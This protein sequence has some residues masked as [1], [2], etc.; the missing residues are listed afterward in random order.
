M[1]TEQSA[2]TPE[3]R[4]TTLRELLIHRPP[5]ARE[6]PAFEVAQAPADPAELFVDWLLAAMRGGVPDAQVLTLG[7][8]GL[9]GTPDARIVTLRDVDPA[10][11]EWWFWGELHS[12]KGRQLAADPRAALTWYWPALGRQVR[13]RGAVRAGSVAAAGETFRLLSPKSR[14]ASLVGRQ[15][16]PL[17][18]VAQFRAAWAAAERELAAD[19]GIVAAGYTQYAV[20]AEEVEFWQG[21]DDRRH[22]RLAYRRPAGTGEWT[23]GV[24]WP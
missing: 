10:N 5:M 12:A 22:V 15:S 24:L 9:D 3:Q 1:T 19:Q 7:T 2:P 17:E 18:E 6:L 8:A 21:A 20:R 23:R 14:A 4:L 11:G 16:E 13:V